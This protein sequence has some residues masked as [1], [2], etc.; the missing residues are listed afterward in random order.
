MAS[1][2]KR[3]SLQYWSLN[4]RYKSFMVQFQEFERSFCA[5]NFQKK[6]KL[7]NFEKNLQ[8]FVIFEGLI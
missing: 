7:I 6:F 4:Y 8:T 3:T 2:D 1:S 5:K